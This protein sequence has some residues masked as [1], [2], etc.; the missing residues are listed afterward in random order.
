MAGVTGKIARK[1]MGHYIDAGSLC[2]GLSPEYERLG[3]DLDE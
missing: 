2:G 1:Y 3:K